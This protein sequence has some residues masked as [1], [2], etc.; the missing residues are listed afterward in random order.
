MV[1][2]ENAIEDKSFGLAFG[3]TPHAMALIPN[4]LKELAG[5]ATLSADGPCCRT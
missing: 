5:A 3:L 1:E 2:D 4:F